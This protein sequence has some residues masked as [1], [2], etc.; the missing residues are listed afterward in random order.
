[1]KFGLSASAAF[2]S[3]AS[4]SLALGLLGVLAASHWGHTAALLNLCLGLLLVGTVPRLWAER[5]KIW[6]P[7]R[8][9]WL[10]LLWAGWTCVVSL[11]PRLSFLAWWQD[12]WAPVLLG[13]A[14]YWRTREQ[15]PDLVLCGLGLGLL[16]LVAMSA[17]GLL[18]VGALALGQDG[19]KTG[20]LH[21]YPGVGQASTAVVMAVVLLAYGQAPAAALPQVRRRRDLLLALALPAYVLVA[22]A[23]LNRMVWPV[24]IVCLIVGLAPSLRRL[25]WRAWLG[26]VLVLVV[27][28]LAVLVGSHLRFGWLADV[29]HSGFWPALTQ[30]SRPA[31]W[32]F[33]WPKLNAYPW[34]GHG[35]GQAVPPLPYLDQVPAE[36]RPVRQFV[37]THAHNWALDLVLQM[38]WPG[39]VLSLVLLGQWLRTSWR[40]AHPSLRVA[41]WVLVL[42]VLGKNMTDDFMRDHMLYLLAGY[43]G[44]LLGL[45]ERLFV[46]GS[47]CAANPCD[48]IAQPYVNRT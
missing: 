22:W 34:F 31:I 40:T 28:L 19:L 12:A 15:G 24:L 37:L 48:K 35:Y 26:L 44:L 8:W 33:W 9:L 16:G 18:S 6:G 23:T 17:W 4:T 32:A 30:D 1:M 11:S 36:L 3:V 5:A 25:S 43:A 42:A 21:Y 14:A 2:R 27:A 29:N 46:S 39:L 10:W 41:M 38:G 13:Y 45:R 47:A 20:L 7:Q